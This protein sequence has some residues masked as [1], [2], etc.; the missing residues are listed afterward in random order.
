MIF[1]FEEVNPVT[2]GDI[3]ILDKRK[4]DFRT[5]F[6]IDLVNKNHMFLIVSVSPI[7]ICPISSNM[8]K[9][10]KKY[11]HNVA[12]L[13]WKDANLRKPSYVGTDVS[14]YIDDDKIYK[15]VGRISNRDKLRILDMY[16]DGERRIAIENNSIKQD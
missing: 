9:V 15:T 14:G 13:D 6:A 12:I 10:K 16:F 4:S 1:L 5:K 8:S 2:V 7:T 11:P 3:I